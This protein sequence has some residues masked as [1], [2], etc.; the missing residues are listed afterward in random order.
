[1][2]AAGAPVLVDEGIPVMYITCTVV[3]AGSDTQLMPISVER[4]ASMSLIGPIVY[5]VSP[6][7]VKVCVVLCADTV[8]GVPVETCCAVVIPETRAMASVIRINPLTILIFIPARYNIARLLIPLPSTMIIFA[9]V[10]MKIST[11]R[12]GNVHKEWSMGTAV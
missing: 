2:L 12:G 7:S 1:M 9:M 5:R 6:P 11:D 4:Q 8:A 10:V 3:P